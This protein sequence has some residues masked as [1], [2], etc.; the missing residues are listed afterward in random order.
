MAATKTREKT[1]RLNGGAKPGNSGNS[2]GKKGRSGRRPEEFREWC[3]SLVE[4]KSHQAEIQ[5]ILDDRTHPHFAKISQLFYA[6]GY[7]QPAAQVELV[8]DKRYVV[9]MP[10]VPESTAAWLSRYQPTELP[11]RN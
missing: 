9:R 7:G 4:A 6:Y 10:E 8:T 5:A 3:R 11:A 1:R 2:G